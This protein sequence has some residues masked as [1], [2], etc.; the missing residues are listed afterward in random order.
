MPKRTNKTTPNKPTSPVRAT[1]TKHNHSATSD[2]L[3]LVVPR[4]PRAC[5]RLFCEQTLSPGFPH[6]CGCRKC[7]PW[8]WCNALKGDGQQC[9]RLRA[10]P[11]RMP[12][13]AYCFEHAL[14]DGRMDSELRDLLGAA[15][16]SDGKVVDAHAKH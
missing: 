4:N 2:K 7:A 1:Q 15:L 8:L 13:Y 9:D 3:C 5:L 6:G 10:F 16:M 11:Q 12:D 14:L